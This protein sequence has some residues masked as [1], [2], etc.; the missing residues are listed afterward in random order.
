[1]QV[2]ALV[3]FA[4]LVVPLNQLVGAVSTC[5][6]IDTL[7]AYLVQ[8]GRQPQLRVGAPLWPASAVACTDSPPVGVTANYVPF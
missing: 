3:Q 1:M 5:L 4:T 8:A 6:Q 7:A 2:R